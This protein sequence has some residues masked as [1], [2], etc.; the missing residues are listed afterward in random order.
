MFR[1][2]DFLG[3]WKW[4][5]IASITLLPVLFFFL[6]WKPGF[7]PEPFG[8][9]LLGPE[10]IGSWPVVIGTNSNIPFRSATE[11][12]FKVRFCGG[13]YE[14][15]RKVEISFGDVERPLWFPTAVS[16]EP[17]RLSATLVTP[18]AVPRN[19]LYLWL[20]VEGQDY[21]RYAISWLV[22]SSS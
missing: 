9:T 17:R 18:G 12:S 3:H 1:S 8:T 19:G 5:N 4:P 16:G 15:F 6:S 10:R 11:V 14:Q 20:A 22:V 21:H 7:K 2:L 13:C